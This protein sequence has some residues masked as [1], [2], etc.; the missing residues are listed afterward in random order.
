MK[1]DV[2]A[3]GAHPDDVELTCGGTII[4]LIKQGRNVGLADLTE[5]E[6][7]T[8]GSRKIRAAEALEAARI[9]GV[10]LRENLQIPDGDIQLSKENLLKAISLI[11]QYKPELLLFPHSKDRHPDHEHAH[12]LCREAWFY[13]GLER[14][15][16]TVDGNK[17]EPHRPKKYYEYMQWLE[18]IPSFVI[19]ISGEYEQRM[20]AARAFRSQFHDPDSKDRET[21]LSSP[22]FME[23]LRTRLEYY[24]DRIG[25][26]YGEPFYSPNMVGLSSLSCLVT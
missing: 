11:R 12:V 24:G 5:G 19:D 23:M 2:L 1:L 21:V 13:A 20:E 9:L 15:E 16:T 6:L 26:K 25:T 17:Q 3:I 14:I 22:E 8:R 10:A 18:F 4:K 7:G